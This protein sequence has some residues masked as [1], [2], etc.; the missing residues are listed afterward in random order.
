M[1][2]SK[3][4]TGRALTPDDAEVS[5]SD[6]QKELIQRGRVDIHKHQTVAITETGRC[7]KARDY[8]KAI[9]EFQRVI[10]T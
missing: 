6:L 10:S 5:S 2:D 4:D 9:E 3:T 1:K 8:G 7:L